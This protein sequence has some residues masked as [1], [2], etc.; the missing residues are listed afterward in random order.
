MCWSRYCLGKSH[1]DGAMKL[2]CLYWLACGTSYRVTADIFA[3]LRATVGRIVHSLVEEMMAIVHQIIDFPIEE[4]EE[5]GAGFA[6]LAGHEAFGCA[7]GA[8]DGCHIRILP[9][10]EPQKK[11]YI[12]RKIFTSV[13]LQGVYSKSKLEMDTYISNTGSV[14][15]TLV[16]RRSP[17]YKESLY[18][19]AGIFLLGDGG[20]PCRT[21]HPHDAIPPAC[22]G[23]VEAHFN[24][25]HAKART[26]IKR[27]FGMLKTSWRAIF[28]SIL[29]IRPLFA[30]KLKAACCILHKL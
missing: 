23:L 17:M 3:M 4:M 19:P 7:A 8:I 14:H 20:Y 30:P 5:M 26:I 13:V 1:M 10:A 15:D 24:K 6:H 28:L 27:T 18:P 21:C 25:H 12:N 22:S 2:K 29:E 16:L 11:C 9:H